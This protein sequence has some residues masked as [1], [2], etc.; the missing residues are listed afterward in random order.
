[1]LLL[2]E[3]TLSQFLGE[4]SEFVRTGRIPAPDERNLT[5]SGFRFERACN[6]VCIL[7]Y[8]CIKRHLRQYGHAQTV[9]DHLYQ[10]VKAGA[11]HGCTC[12]QFGPVAGRQCVVLE[13]V[14][15]LKQQKL[16]LSHRR[17]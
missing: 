5:A 11:D 10:R 8:P 13:A 12:A 7:E 17:A 15:V 1:M 9:I 2:R 6:H 14:T 16:A 3:S 4:Q